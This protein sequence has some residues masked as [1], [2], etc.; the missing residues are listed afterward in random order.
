MPAWLYR[1][2]YLFLLLTVSFLGLAWFFTSQVK[3]QGN[4]FGIAYTYNIVDEEIEDGDI[5]GMNVNGE[6]VRV[7]VAYDERIFGIYVEDPTMVLRTD[8]SYSPVI[9]DGD[10]YVNVTTINGD[11]AIGDFITSSEI[12][13][14]GM[15]A[16]GTQSGKVVGVAMESFNS[17]DGVKQTVEVN[18]RNELV[19]KE[20]AFGKI[21]VALG[22]GPAPVSSVTQRGGFLGLV[23]QLGF[24]ILKALQGSEGTAK[25]LRYIMAALV[26]IATLAFSFFTFGRNITKGIESI[27]RNPLAKLQIQSMIVLNLVLIALVTVGGVILTLIIVRF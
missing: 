22:I 8:E 19:Q 16:G 3:A 20:I 4:Q 17:E 18:E 10:A 2:W 23:A 12:A 14:K 15:Y 9:R 7:N 26:A 5:I 27:G 24:D 6:M 1:K 21:K 13:G 25:L 11:I